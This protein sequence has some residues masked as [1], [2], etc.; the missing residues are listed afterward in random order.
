MTK[1]S[2]DY[3][4][5]CKRGKAAIAAGG[6]WFRTKKFKL[7][8]CLSFAEQRKMGS[9]RKCKDVL[10]F[11]IVYDQ[12]FVPGEK[13]TTPEDIAAWM[14]KHWAEEGEKFTAFDGKII[15]S[16]LI[17]GYTIH[18]PVSKEG[19]EYILSGKE[20]Y[21]WPTNET[22]FGILMPKINFW[23]GDDFK[24]PPIE[25]WQPRQQAIQ[26]NSSFNL[27]EFFSADNMNKMAEERNKQMRNFYESMNHSYAR[28]DDMLKGRILKDR[29]PIT[30]EPL[31]TE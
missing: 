5:E 9:K 19:I 6:Y 14:N 3:F 4:K 27:E 20:R 31:D 21:T 2:I 18:S 8:T 10:Q 16:N 1:R 22:K 28:I 15:R 29:H 17:E 26:E 23:H 13:P 25:Y 30:Y 11:P 24:V 7:Q 12:P